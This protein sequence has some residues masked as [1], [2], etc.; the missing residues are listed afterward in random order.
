MT[1]QRAT[2]PRVTEI[3]TTSVTSLTASTALPLDQQPAAVYLAGLAQGLRRTLRDALNTI[4]ECF[5]AGPMR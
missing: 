2:T 4:A 1:P 3:A 5:R